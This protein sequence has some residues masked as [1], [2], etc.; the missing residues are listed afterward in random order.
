MLDAWQYSSSSTTGNASVPQLLLA[1]HAD[2]LARL[3]RDEHPPGNWDAYVLCDGRS[4]V[5][6]HRRAYWWA[7]P[8]LR[9]VELSVMGSNAT[10]RQAYLDVAIRSGEWYLLAQRLDGAVYRETAPDG[11]TAAYGLANSAAAAA[12]MLWMRLHAL[13][14]DKRW[15]EPIYRSMRYLLSQQINHTIT[16]DNPHIQGAVIEATR[17]PPDGTDSSPWYVRDIASSFF[18]QA[19]AMLLDMA[20]A[21]KG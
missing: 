14:G 16:D 18:A 19:A 2:M 17:P 7:T 1:A 10:T 13:T 15:V 9:A 5:L 20:A 6:C 11:K 12:C 4:D 21:E 8:F 3:Q